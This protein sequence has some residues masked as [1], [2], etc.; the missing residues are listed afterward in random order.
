MVTLR[1]RRI[2]SPFSSG[3]GAEQQGMEAE[4]AGG[5]AVRRRNGRGRQQ[6]QQHQQP[7]QNQQQSNQGRDSQR[8]G[9]RRRAGRSLSLGRRRHRSRSSTP[10][11]SA[12][13]ESR[14]LVASSS[15]SPN[16]AG[17]SSA[18]GASVAGAAAAGTSPGKRKPESRGITASIRRAKK[19]LTRMGSAGSS[20]HPPNGN[21][22]PDGGG[23]AAGAAAENAGGNS[24]LDEDQLAR[25]DAGD[26][27]DAAANDVNEGA[28]HGAEGGENNAGEGSHSTPN[29]PTLGILRSPSDEENV[30]PPLALLSPNLGTLYAHAAGSEA[31]ASA[32]KADSDEAD[33]FR[34]ASYGAPTATTTSFPAPRAKNVLEWMRTDLPPELL[35][36]VLSF[37][38]SRR[39]KAL[40]GVDRYWNEVAKDESVWRVVCEDTG[41]W[42]D[43]DEVPKSWAHHY[44]QNPCVPIDY[45]TVEAA[46]DAV[47]SGPLC[48]SVENQVRQR[49]REQRT[50][51][52]ILLH[53]GPYFLRGPLVAN[54]AA[55]AVVTIEAVGG[56]ERKLGDHEHGTRW[57]LNYHE[58]GREGNGEPSTP[59][60]PWDYPGSAATHKRPSSPTLRQIFGSCGPRSS[61][62][63][64]ASVV[65]LSASDRGGGRDV[66]DGDQSANRAAFHKS[67]FRGPPC[68]PTPLLCL[69]S[70]RD[71]EPLIRVRRG[72]VV[73]RGLKIL[74][75]CEGTDIWNGNAAVQV[76]RAFGRNGRP[77]RSGD[78]PDGGYVPPA[79]DLDDC[80]VASL[81]GRG[82]VVIDGTSASVAD[83]SFHDSAATGV[84]VGGAGSLCALVRTDV[85]DNGV[86]NS[87]AANGRGVARGHSGVY[88]E[89][90]LADLRDCNV[91][92]NT[93][94][95][96]SATSTEQARLRME[97]TDVRSNRSDQVELPPP[98]S[99]RRAVRNNVI[100]RT[101]LGRPRSRRLRESLVLMDDLNNTP[102]GR[103]SAAREPTTPQSPL[104]EVGDW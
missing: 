62:S 6:N 78:G 60:G 72:R 17:R 86:G 79:A 36:K 99:G 15:S 9:T 64:S 3:G 104:G 103:R 23:G 102:R 92:G 39:M 65:D 55:G 83:C 33:G 56:R 88:V 16:V 53:P 70:K 30:P 35:P 10:V 45:D 42:S 32:R 27:I 81:S 73:L 37:C 47:S 93:L 100:S 66:D 1:S 4:P 63:T 57:L 87:R 19:M 7:G 29:Q 18:A 85:V 28:D 50:S 43:G 12:V 44:K 52:R 34:G 98:E 82:L 91:S 13:A 84:Y 89:Q 67:C 71:N 51:C 75:R 69:E 46:L 54:V 8:Q 48:E 2:R 74:H 97:E 38:G 26:E 101:G 68:R 11:D 31:R 76:Q 20:H 96:I 49:Y 22:H 41:K 90:G 58:E 80:D 59:A 77:L 24:A 94:T 21:A 5:Q 95:G 61:S 25:A 14:P 40:A